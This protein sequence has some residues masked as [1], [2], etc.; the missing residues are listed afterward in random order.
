M[1]SEATSFSSLRTVLLTVVAFNLLFMSRTW[2]CPFLSFDLSYILLKPFVG[3]HPL[4]PW[5]VRRAPWSPAPQAADLMLCPADLR[6][7]SWPCPLPACPCIGPAPFTSPLP[8]Y[9]FCLEG[10]PHPFPS[11]PPHPQD[12][13]LL[14][15]FVGSIPKL[16]L[17][18]LLN[19]PQLQFCL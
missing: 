5:F 4:V 11:I 10:F 2:D 19:T 6:P 12:R 17:F 15:P 3:M 8:G 14:P 18:L 9:S 1:W 13:T 16:G 7:Y